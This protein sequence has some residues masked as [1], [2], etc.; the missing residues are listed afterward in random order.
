VKDHLRDQAQSGYYVAGPPRFVSAVT[1]VL[2][3]AGVNQR[4]IRTDEFFGYG[5]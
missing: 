2:A 3:A 1:E 4:G 5:A